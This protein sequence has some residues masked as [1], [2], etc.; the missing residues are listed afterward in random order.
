MIG[1]LPAYNVGIDCEDIQRWRKMLPK[2]EQGSQR[3]LF[4][5]REHVY[6]RSF[7]DPSPHYAAR[8]CAKE[9]L[10]KALS[11]FYKLDLREVEVANDSE[12]KPF[13]ILNDPAVD[14]IKI[15]I[16]LS[17]SHSKET[18]MA[19]VIVSIL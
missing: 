5:E 2:L 1:N 7:K 10:L 9:A 19:V 13:F 14:K 6:C 18:A 12:G 8:W 11:P 3:K 15:E 16:K 17:M 4:T